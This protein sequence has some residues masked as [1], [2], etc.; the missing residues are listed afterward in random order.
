MLEYGLDSQHGIN[1]YPGH[2]SPTVSFLPG[3]LA[4]SNAFWT[5]MINILTTSPITGTRLVTPKIVLTAKQTPAVGFEK[6]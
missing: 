3:T 6:S 5:G 1:T 2:T 4:H